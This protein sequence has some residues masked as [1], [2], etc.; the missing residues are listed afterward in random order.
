[1]NATI[2]FCIFELA[3]ESNFTLNTQFWIFGPNLP[4]KSISGQ[5]KNETSQLNFA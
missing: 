1:M 4:K 5:K 2:G 3:E